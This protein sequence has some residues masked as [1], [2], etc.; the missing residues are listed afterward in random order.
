MKKVA[1]CCPVYNCLDLTKDFFESVKSKHDLTFIFF[2]NGST[3]KTMEWLTS[4]KG[5]KVTILSSP[6]NKGVTHGANA[7]YQEA[8]DLGFDYIVYCNNDIVLRPETID[9]MVWAWD[10]RQDER[11]VRISGLDIR[12]EN[13]KTRADALKRVFDQDLSDAN[14]IFGGSYTFFIWDRKAI[15]KVGLLDPNVDYYDDNIHAEEILRRGCVGVTFLP[16]IVFHKG[17]ATIRYNPKDREAF[18][19]KNRLD[20]KYAFEYFAVKNQHEMR[21]KY[22]ERRPYWSPI[23]EDINK[24]LKEL[25]KEYL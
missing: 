25:P 24:K 23:L 21:E 2:N 5:K 3:D 15:E 20:S 7:L 6:V 16:G 14:F 4:I 10:N 13:Y 11:I 9:A 19:R 8:Y 22:E 1:I 17:S 18:E 12:E